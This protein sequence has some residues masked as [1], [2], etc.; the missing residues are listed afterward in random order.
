MSSRFLTKCS[1]YLAVGGLTS[2]MVMRSILI[3]R[4]KRQE[5]FREAMK[6]IRTHPG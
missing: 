2:V 4:V 3:D 1:V 6:E 5:Y